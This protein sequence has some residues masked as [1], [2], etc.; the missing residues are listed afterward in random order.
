M[1]KSIYQSS[2]LI[3]RTQMI[4]QHYLI[5]FLLFGMLFS[6]LTYFP[7]KQTA[8]Q[9]QQGLPPLPIPLSRSQTPGQFG[10]GSEFGAPVPPGGGRPGFQQPGQ[11]Q[12]MG[13]TFLVRL[14]KV[15]VDEAR[16]PSADT[17]YVGLSGKVGQGGQPMSATRFLGDLG[18]HVTRNVGIR[19][20]P[21]NVPGNQMLSFSYLVE[22]KGGGG[23][24]QNLIDM[25]KAAAGVLATPGVA[26][27]VAAAEQVVRFVAGGLLPGGCNGIVAADEIILSKGQLQQMTSRGPHTETKFYPGTDS[28]RGCGS[29]SRYHVTW[30]V[31]RA[32]P[33]V[34]QPP[35]LSRPQIPG[36]FQQ[37]PPGQFQQ[38]PPGQF[39]QT[40]PGQ[41]PR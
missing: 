16:S 31:M 32:E 13:P 18:D 28:P 22:N 29:N 4:R 35:P 37:T 12:Q 24:S 7:I 41:F 26:A 3:L 10:G 11:F 38:T 5:L 36:Q 2:R 9:V 20:G 8:A 30:T 40:P 1:A 23:V 19:V 6:G 39:Q 15:T 33:Q 17:V 27:G 34:L 14:D 25:G 21:F